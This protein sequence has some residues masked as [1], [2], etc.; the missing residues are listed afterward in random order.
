M[1]LKK[2]RT[3]FISAILQ[4]MLFAE[5]TVLLPVKPYLEMRNLKGSQEKSREEFHTILLGS[6]VSRMGVVRQEG[7]IM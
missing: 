5:M 6:F 7:L 3:D 2:H 4:R 1:K